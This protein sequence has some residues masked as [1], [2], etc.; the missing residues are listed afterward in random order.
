MV[1]PTAPKLDWGQAVGMALSVHRTV[2]M[3]PKVMIIAGS[4]DHLQ[5][6]GLLTLLTDRSLP[7]NEVI[8]GAI[9]TLISALTEV[10]TS[11]KER[12]T[13]NVVKTIFVLSPGNAA[14]PEPLQFECTMVTTLTWSS[15]R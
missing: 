10:E 7:S 4:N 6:R 9:M 2:S 15:P 3:D 1:F 12:F 8:G 13:K 11:V 5:S 14:L